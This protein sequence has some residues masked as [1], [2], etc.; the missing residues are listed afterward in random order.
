MAALASMASAALMLV[1]GLAPG[2]AL[3]SGSGDQSVITRVTNPDGTV[4][5]TIYTPALGVSPAQLAAL[6]NGRGIAAK[7]EKE[8]AAA[9]VAPCGYGTANAWANDTTCFVRVA[10]GQSHSWVTPTSWLSSPRA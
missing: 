1:V 5:E 2:Q 6:L 7:V 9:A 3:A 10:G 4:T 8:A